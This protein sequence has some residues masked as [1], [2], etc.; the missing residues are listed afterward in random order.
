[1]ELKVC[2]SSL[3]RVVAGTDQSLSNSESSYEL[4]VDM[5]EAPINSYNIINRQLYFSWNFLHFSCF[6]RLVLISEKQENAYVF[7]SSIQERTLIPDKS[8]IGFDAE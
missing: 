4:N 2:G 5:R 6:C 7:K 3:L 1:M 8:V